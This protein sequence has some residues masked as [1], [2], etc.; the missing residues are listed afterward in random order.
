MS[1]NVEIRIE[2]GG[3]TAEGFDARETVSRAARSA[4]EKGCTGDFAL[5]VSDVEIS[6]LLT[7]D[8]TVRTLNKTYRN[9][10]KPTNVLSFASLDDEDEIIEDPFL[11]GDIIIAFETTKREAEEGGKTFADHLYHLTVHGVLHLLGYDHID[12]A[13]AREMES[14]ETS[15]LAQA[16][17]KDPYESDE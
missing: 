8:A 5:P 2:N 15:I 7:D 6:V 1:L 10:D 3:W 13:D 4:W 16:G 14:L 9:V 17:I 11:A 12:E